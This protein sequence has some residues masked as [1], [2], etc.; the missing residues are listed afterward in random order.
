M[1]RPSTAAP[2]ATTGGPDEQGRSAD[3]P[4]SSVTEVVPPGDEAGE[5]GSAHLVAHRNGAVTWEDGRALA[6]ALHEVS[7]ALTVVLGWLDALDQT[8]DPTK[9]HA[10]LAVAREHAR[11]GRHLAR[12]AI[13]AEEDTDVERRGAAALA[14][15]AVMSVRPRALAR[16][17]RVDLQELVEGDVALEDEAPA[18][19]VLTNLLLNAIDFTPPGGRIEVTLRSVATDVI[20]TVSDEGPGIPIERHATLFADPVSTRRGGAGIGLTH[21]R[22]L[23]CER[24]GNLRLLPSERGACFELTWPR[25][26][27]AAGAVEVREAQANR[28]LNGARILVVEDDPA[29]ASLLELSLEAKGAE[30]VLVDGAHGLGQLLGGRPVIDAALLDL[31][32]L[33]GHLA[34]WLDEIRRHAPDAPLVLV[35]GHPNGIPDEAAGRFSAWVRKPFEMGELLHTLGCLLRQHAE[36]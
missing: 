20:V 19:Q 29:I 25:A 12:R 35:S 4:R 34:E 5:P 2:R 7:N 23:A 15:F 8:D 10:A 1:S 27:S 33:A 31:S 17:V 32:P 18:L 24:G 13:G 22:R 16:D 11:R 36:P 14:R 30:V 26:T 21:S 9:V 3:E 28:A 6:G